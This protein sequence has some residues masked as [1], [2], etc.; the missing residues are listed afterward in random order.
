MNNQTY[1]EYI[2]AYITDDDNVEYEVCF[3]L[4]HGSGRWVFWSDTGYEWTID[5][6]VE[7]VFQEALDEEGNIVTISQDLIYKASEIAEE[8]YWERYAEGHY[9]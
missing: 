3:G 9:N 4:Y 5:R 6:E 2:A 8:T 1:D 7:L